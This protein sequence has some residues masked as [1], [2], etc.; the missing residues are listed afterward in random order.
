VLV[1]VHATS[2]N[3]VDAMIAAG[4]FRRIQDYRFPAVFGRD[5]AGVVEQVGSAVTRFTPGDRVYGY[6]KRDHI[7][8]GTFAEYVTVPEDVGLGPIPAGSSLAQA[9]TLG[10]AGVTALECV[11]AVPSGPGEIVLVNGA[12]G[13]VGSFAVQIAAARG[14]EVIATARTPE[15]VSYV[16]GL[17]AAHVVDW[18]AGDLLT[19]VRA[20]APDG[21]DA[22]VDLVKHVDSTEMGVGEDEAHHAFARLCRGLLREGGRAA[23]VTNGGVPELLGGIP[24]ANVHSTPTPE[25][26]ARLAELVETG[27][28]AVPI[29]ASYAFEEIE[30]AFARLAA[31]PALGKLSVVLTQEA[32]P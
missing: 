32:R 25:S 13:G 11:D 6:V 4:F 19:T 27:A 12:T 18:S 30:A 29:Q 8:D 10:Q 23:S 16:R 5:V 14:A 1:R 2:V 31:G 26:L 17:G 9:G 7:G 28:V 20:V 22:L 3:P 15:Q 24:C 21:I